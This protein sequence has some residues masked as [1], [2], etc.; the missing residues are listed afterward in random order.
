MINWFSHSDQINFTKIIFIRGSCL[1]VEI[2][3]DEEAYSIKDMHV[4]SSVITCI[5]ADMEML[6][7]F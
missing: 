6:L 4:A 1:L 3:R 5:E 7:I 2:H